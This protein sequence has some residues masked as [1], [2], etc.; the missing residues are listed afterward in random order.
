MDDIHSNGTAIDYY[1][2]QIQQAQ[3]DPRKTHKIPTILRFLEEAGMCPLHNP[4][5]KPS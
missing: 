1:I 5:P 2:A 3:K 4:A